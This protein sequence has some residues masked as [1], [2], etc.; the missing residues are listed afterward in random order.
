MQI[1]DGQENK[2]KDL[3]YKIGV[4]RC[5]SG[6]RNAFSFDTAWKAACTKS[7]GRLRRRFFPR[8]SRI[9]GE[10]KSDGIEVR[11]IDRENCDRQSAR[12]LSPRNARGVTYIRAFHRDRFSETGHFSS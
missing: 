5:R 2:K 3:A 12:A 8:K 7:R 6:A 9:N 4:E 1:V 11:P 10:G